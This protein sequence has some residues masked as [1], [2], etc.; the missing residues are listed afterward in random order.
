MLVACPSPA[1]LCGSRRT[2]PAPLLVRAVAA[3]ALTFLILPILTVCAAQ[4]PAPS[5]K[6]ELSGAPI[7]VNAAWIADWSLAD[8]GGLAPI[9]VDV[10]PSGVL[11]GIERRRHRLFLLDSDGAWLGLAGQ[12][13]TDGSD[14]GFAERVFARSGLKIFTLDPERRI[15]DRF[16]LRGQWETRFDLGGAAQQAGVTVGTAVD[17]G[18]DR[19]GE[20]YI[21]DAARGTILHFG[22]DGQFIASLE[23]WGDW[24]PIDARALEVNGRGQ[25]FLLGGQPVDV[26]VLEPSGRLIERRPVVPAGEE[27]F[28]PTALAVDAWGNAFVG[29]G[30]P[31]KVRVLPGGGAPAWWIAVPAGRSLRVA[32]LAVDTQHRLLIADPAGGCIHVFAVEYRKGAEARGPGSEP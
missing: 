11:A 4:E 26:W 18:L 1:R 30:R 3:R 15:V 12:A 20:L 24:P 16:D 27:R 8:R 32:D 13:G 17:F 2:L 10:H 23:T 14:V 25:L 5:L 21:L 28:E 7:P 31:G 29:G 9:A 22:P 19:A 6:V